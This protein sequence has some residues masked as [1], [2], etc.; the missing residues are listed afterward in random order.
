MH[1]QTYSS[2]IQYWPLDR[3]VI[4]LNHGSFGACPNIVLEK[5]NEF[6]HKLEHE[7]VRFLIRE[8]EPLLDEARQ[9]LSDFLRVQSKDLVFVRNATEGVN[10]VL[11]SI[12]WKKDDNVVITN[13]IYP[14]CRNSLL[15]LSAIH[16]FSI[17]EVFIPYPFTSKTEYIEPILNAIQPNTRLLL[18]D[19]ISSPTAVVF[20][21]ED[22]AAALKETNTMILVDGAHAPCSIPL[23]IPLLNVDF[24]T[25][26]CHKWMCAPKGSAF[27]WAASDVQNILNPLSYSL[28]N[29]RGNSFQDRFYWTGT[30]DPTPLLTIPTALDFIDSLA[31]NGVNEMMKQNHQLCIEMTNMLC[32]TLEIPLP[33]PND[34]ISSM[35]ALPISSANP[36]FPGQIDPIQDQLFHDYHIEIPVIRWPDS[37]SRLIRFSC[38][39]YNNPAQYKLLGNCLKKITV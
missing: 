5:Q 1:S 2:S 26:N 25:G 10:T 38:H 18:I 31:T 7:P 12:Q 23:D 37:T 33:C 14:A 8:L 32:K 30:S 27:L 11:H 36:L 15:H 22:I 17:T 34:S 29:C 19:H 9:R 16:G 24:Y 6:R 13:H 4:F 20:P 35:C 21:V 39:S 3:N 28:I